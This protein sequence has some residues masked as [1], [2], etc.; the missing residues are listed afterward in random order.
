MFPIRIN[1]GYRY[2]SGLVHGI[3][4]QRDHLVFRKYDIA[5]FALVLRTDQYTWCWFTNVDYKI[6][7]KSRKKSS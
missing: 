7:Q 4:H 6:D 5:F 1:N 2:I 3:S